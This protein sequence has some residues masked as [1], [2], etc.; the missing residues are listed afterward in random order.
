MPPGGT[1]TVCLQMMK[2]RKAEMVDK[3]YCMSSYL[4]L[5][6]VYDK[7]K[8]FKEN[9]KHFDFEPIPEEKQIACASEEE[10]EEQILRILGTKDLTK[11]ALL[12]SGGMDS[13]IL[14]S[15]MPKGT[16]AYTARCMAP[17]AVDETQRAKQYCEFYGLEH[18][19]VDITW[20]DYLDSIDFL[21]LN[22]GCPVNSNEPQVYKLAQ[23][24]KF[25]GG[26]GGGGGRNYSVRR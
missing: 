24:A 15:Y 2:R 11:A 22:D 1:V 18:I 19:V 12:L 20:Q 25:G 6:H 8:T 13:A 16:K 7:E 14:A 10:I 17:G 9:M 23:A 26:G 5:R 4:A 3:N 21:M